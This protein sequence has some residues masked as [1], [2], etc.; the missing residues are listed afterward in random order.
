MDTKKPIYKAYA[1]EEFIDILF[2]HP[3]GLA[4]ARTA[5]KLNLTPDQITYISMFFGIA[6]GL[7][8]SSMKT[9]YAGFCLLIISSIF[10]SA[11]GQLAR[12]TKNG[13]FRGKI[14]DG[15]TGYFMFT[16]SYIGLSILYLSTPANMGPEFIIP[17]AI[18]GAIASALQSS[19]YD[20]YRTCFASITIKKKVE[21]FDK[22]KELSGFLKFSY[23]SYFSYQKL[24]AKNHINLME[25]IRKR[26][27]E[28]IVGENEA[29][30]YK[31]SNS[32]IIRGWNLLGDNTRF[33]L[34]L[35]AIILHKPHWYFLFVLGPLNIVMFFLTIRQKRLDKEF[36]NGLEGGVE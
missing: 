12:M 7:M 27:P 11:D 13:T 10:D 22:G 28:N 1:M 34:I 24:L 2:F 8:L 25:N 9:A 20:F 21:S 4:V 33:I 15:L 30:N 17:L 14:L 31:K 32:K 3:L 5:F 23:L 36:L 35:T 16:S 26:C 18:V 29:Q 19:L 6:G